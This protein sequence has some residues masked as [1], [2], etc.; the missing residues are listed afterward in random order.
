MATS[1][2]KVDDSALDAIA[3]V[4]ST[5]RED[6]QY[7]QVSNVNVSNFVS[8][9]L[10]GHSNYPIWKAQMLHFIESQELLY[11]ID[12]DRY[13][14][15]EY[16]GVHK[17]WHYER[18]VLCWIL[19]SMTENQLK[20]LKEF[21][22][23][24]SAKA[25]WR[26]VESLYMPPISNTE[27]SPGFLFGKDLLVDAPEI[28]TT[29][30]ITREIRERL[31]EAA[32][33]GCW[34]KAKSLLKTNKNAATKPITRDGNTILHIAV[35]MG[36]NHFVEKL[37]QFLTDGRD[38]ETKNY[39]G[40]TALHIAALVSNEYAAQLLVQKRSRLLEIRDSGQ[41]SPLDTALHESNFNISAYLLK[42]TPTS[43]LFSSLARKVDSAIKGAIYTKQ[44]DLAL[45]LLKTYADEL[46]DYD[47]I[48]YLLTI[49]FPTDLGF[50]ESFIYP[51]LHKVRQKVVK[52]CSLLFHPNFWDKCVDDISRVKKIY[53]NTCY[54]WFGNFF[55][56]L[57]VP[58]VTLYPIYQLICLLILGLHLTLS[59]LY[60][61]LW[62]V[63]AVTVRPIKNIE[64]KKKEY[65]EAKEILSLVCDRI[66]SSKRR[67]KSS[68]L[69]AVLVGAYEVVDE[70][71]F[72]SPS[73]INC[74]N[75]EGH[76]IIQLAIINRSEK[77]Y[78]LIHHIILRISS[79]SS[80]KD[81][82]QNSL[83]HLA[84]R[85]SPSFVLE[86]TTGAALQLQRELLWYQ[87]VEKLV[88][89]LDRTDKNLNEETSAMVFTREHQDL[90]KEG[91]NWM[92]T[93]AESC[94]IT[95]AL[96]VT[97]VFAAAITVPGGNNQESGIPV[98]KRETAFTIFALSNAFSLFTSATALLLF[99]SILTAR[100]SEKDFLVSLPRRL[101]FGLLTLFLSTTAMIIAFGAILFLVFCDQRPW[102]LAPIVVFACLPIS[103]I[104]TIKLPLLIDLIQSTYLPIFGKQSYLKSCKTNQKNTIF[105]K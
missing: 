11:I 65:K 18:L 24:D 72:M 33:E 63:L 104:V 86:R 1:S 94:S 20:N 28:E 4:V 49:T 35:E 57:L 3:S 14:S 13:T 102:M 50:T 101:I 2:N 51:S 95:A 15:P 91:E 29:S 77:V 83:L 38:I 27:D 59:I 74:K 90:M 21:V 31:Y 78:N 44:H 87:E 45:T 73:A 8:V 25:V 10:S 89:P 68:I 40:Q 88:L 32:I 39:E 98:F 36:H 75:E 23:I 22:H 99:L 12:D 103:V 100:F 55:I 80:M 60:L 96:I 66:G 47:L 30:S 70:I 92:K 6:L 79:Y 84:G 54:S 62:K 76:N 42:T 53:N 93:T 105:R 19:G 17:S 61:F 7:I 69:E 82:F 37:L 46:L 43:D 71:L 85:L 52:R 56:I 9:K 34:W 64:K 97:V 81:S 41:D 58:I 48:L 5:L 16:K 67:Y 26:E